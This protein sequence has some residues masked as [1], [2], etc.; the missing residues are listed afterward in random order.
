MMALVALVRS[1]GG[2]H[3]HIRDDQTVTQR[4]I[5]DGVSN[6]NARFYVRAHITIIGYCPWSFH[7]G[8]FAVGGSHVVDRFGGNHLIVGNVTGMIDKRFGLTAENIGWSSFHRRLRV[9][10]EDF[11]DAG[12]CHIVTDV[13]LI[14][15]IVDTVDLLSDDILFDRLNATTSQ[16][17]RGG[18]V[19]CVA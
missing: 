19:A 14:P 8:V 11:K 13:V 1:A 18:C 15:R 9:L 4:P 10:G 17:K 5:I 12:A 7:F 16:K 3:C 6:A 2:R